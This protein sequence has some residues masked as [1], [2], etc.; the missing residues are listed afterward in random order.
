M[1]SIRA[2]DCPSNGT[3]FRLLDTFDECPQWLAARM[4]GRHLRRFVMLRRHGPYVLTDGELDAMSGAL[5]T[6]EE[7]PPS[8]GGDAGGG[9][10][11]GGGGA[12]FGAAFLYFY[13]LYMAFY[14]DHPVLLDLRP[15]KSSTLLRLQRGDP[16][17]VDID[18]ADLLQCMPG[19]GDGKGAT[20]LWKQWGLRRSD[21]LTELVIS[22]PV[23]A[24]VTV[25][26]EG[27]LSRGASGGGSGGSG[28][29]GGGGNVGAL[30]S[31]ELAEIERDLPSILLAATLAGAE[32]GGGGSQG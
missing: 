15:L 28:G 25:G 16:A 26:S 18:A 13:R 20:L 23:V 1:S 29:S 11:G 2:P 21:V 32:G 5:S 31:E 24:S 12:L 7:S 3:L 22:S 19:G 8:D 9:G 30:L 4:E 27:A 6:F 14:H 17:I 10:G